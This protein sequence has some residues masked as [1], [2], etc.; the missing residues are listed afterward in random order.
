MRQA[1]PRLS[2]GTRTAAMCLLAI[3]F[4]TLSGVA[5]AAADDAHDWT[6]QWQTYWRDGQALGLLERDGDAVKGTYEPQGG[7]IEGRVEGRL[8]RGSWSVDGVSG[9]FL[10][11][12]AADGKT[13]TGRFDSSEY[14]NGRR[15]IPGE[16]DTTSAFNVAS[17]PRES[18]RTI[19]TAA[20][21]AVFAGNAA[22][23]RI[24]EPLLLY[25][26]TTTDTRNR[27]RRRTL[28]WHLLNMS[29]FPMPSFLTRRSLTGV[30]ANGA[31]S[32]LKSVLPTTRRARSSMPS[33]PG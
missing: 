30:C 13:F 14:W 7:L 26:G 24:Y 8:L 12:L 11:A 4:I 19:I 10:F 6:G 15:V 21:E 23:E 31:V 2:V 27:N 5:W 28:L 3:A 22:A 29:T 16:T 33:W 20:N 32:I 18:L 25:E 17:T 9:G 1:S